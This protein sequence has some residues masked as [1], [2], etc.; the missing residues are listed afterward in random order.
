MKRTR[1][2]AIIAAMLLTSASRAERYL[3]TDLGT[4]GV[5]AAAFALNSGGRVAGAS[6]A[7]DTELKA[8]I[9]DGGGAFIEPIDGRS[10]S[11][12]L[13]ISDAGAVAFVSYDL[14]GIAPVGGVRAGSATINLGSLVPRAINNGGAVAGALVIDDPIYGPIEHAARW[15]AGTTTD[16]GALG[17]HFSNAF[18]IN[19]AGLIVGGAHIAGDVN[20][21]PFVWAGGP[22]QDMGTLGGASGQAYDI[23]DHNQAV[24]WSNIAGG[25]IHAFRYALDSRGNVVS[26]IDLGALGSSSSFARGI[27]NSGDVVGVSD[28]AAVRWRDGAIVDLNTLIPPGDEWK[29]EAA[30]AINDAGEIVGT[31]THRGAPASFLLRPALSADTNCDGGVDFFDIDPFLLALFDPPAY[32]AAFPECSLFQSDVN[33]DGAVNFFD[34][35]PFVGCLFAGGCP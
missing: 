27:N 24:G 12:G 19:E 11:M 6:L 15:E 17:G 34:I 33:E 10:Q 1:S 32:A 20:V 21:H 9:W 4:T 30:W 2:A 18:A 14:G 13:G 5:S 25:N 23:N 28:A 16:L 29:L 35:D 26:R 31:G 7:T 8:L 22:M 3:V